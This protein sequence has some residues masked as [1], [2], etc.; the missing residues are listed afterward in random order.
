[1]AQRQHPFRTEHHTN[2]WQGFLKSG[3]DRC[4]APNGQQRHVVALRHEL[5]V[6]WAGAVRILGPSPSATTPLS[7][8]VSIFSPR[9]HGHIAVQ[10][11]RRPTRAR[12]GRTDHLGSAPSPAT[13]QR[14]DG[15]TQHVAGNRQLVGRG[16]GIG[17][18]VVQSR[19]ERAHRRSTAT[20]RRRQNACVRSGPRRP[21]NGRCAHRDVS[22]E[23]PLANRPQASKPSRP[24]TSV[25]SLTDCFLMF[26]VIQNLLRY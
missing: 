1:M 24:L 21:A 17:V 8:S 10:P 16:T 20:R 9:R 26:S 22:I 19:D 3:H 6:V 18:G 25:V 14:C 13:A 2:M 7:N 15:G 11:R 4:R 23:K 12:A 5:G